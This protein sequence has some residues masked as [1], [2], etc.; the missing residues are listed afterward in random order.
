[1]QKVVDS[2]ILQ[3]DALS[4][5]LARSL[6]HVVILTDYAFMEAYK[7]DT[8]DV[9]YCSM[10][11]L[12]QYPKQVIVLKG[13]QAVCGLSGRG[14]GLQKRLIDQKQTL[15]FAEY[16]AHL[17][18]AKRGVTGINYAREARL[19]MDR[20]FGDAEDFGEALEGMTQQFKANEVQIIRRRL[21]YTEEMR[22]K[23]VQHI[24]MIA[25]SMFRSHPKVPHLPKAV[26]LP[27]QNSYFGWPCAHIC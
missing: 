8:L 25:A 16:S 1:M 17:I 3:C 7:A 9:L 5:Y 26:E 14:A 21:P 27:D 24:L 12:S 22:T 19:Q 6:Q 10:E 4:E 13:T 18:A 2:N 23:V 20:I 11:I 15:G